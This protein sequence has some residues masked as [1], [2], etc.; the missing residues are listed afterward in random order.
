V[1]VTF[2]TLVENDAML[3]FGL[4]QTAVNDEEF[5]NDWSK[6]RA[7]KVNVFIPKNS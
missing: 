2:N 4:K 3:Y 5:F 6:R 1:E 7:F